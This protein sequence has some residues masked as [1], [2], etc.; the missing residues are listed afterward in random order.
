VL[1]DKEYPGNQTFQ[2][3]SC[4][5]QNTD[6]PDVWRMMHSSLGLPGYHSACC[7]INNTGNMYIVTMRTL[8]S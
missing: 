4:R 5:H 7:C 1:Y 6:D 8:V 3:N 2:N